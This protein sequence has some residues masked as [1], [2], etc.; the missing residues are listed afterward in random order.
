MTETPPTPQASRQSDSGAAVA[1]KRFVRHPAYILT[2]IF[3]AMP[4]SG[5]IM[6][7][8]QMLLGLALIS[9]H[10]P[11]TVYLVCKLRDN[12]V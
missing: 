8:G 9:M 12:D 5:I 4:I 3:V 1:L 7:R 2:V 6:G 10:L 11:L